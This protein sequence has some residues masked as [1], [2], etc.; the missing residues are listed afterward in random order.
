MIAPDL[1]EDLEDWCV[2]R[3]DTC[4]YKLGLKLDVIYAEKLNRRSMC[5]K[6]RI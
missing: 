6:E 4:H 5:K 2:T 1:P 3:R